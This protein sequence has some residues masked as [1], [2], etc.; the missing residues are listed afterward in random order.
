MVDLVKDF[1]WEPPIRLDSEGFYSERVADATLSGL[2][3]IKFGSL[4]FYIIVL[5]AANFISSGLKMLNAVRIEGFI[6]LGC[7]I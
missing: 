7:Y 3:S 4:V 5:I 6:A 2:A 1:S